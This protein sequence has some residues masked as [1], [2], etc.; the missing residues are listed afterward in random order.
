MTKPVTSET[1]RQTESTVASP[2]LREIGAKTL[3][4][5]P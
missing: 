1:I 3:P 2:Y 5:Q 4:N